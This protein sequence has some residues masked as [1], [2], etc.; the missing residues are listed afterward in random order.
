MYFASVPV[1]LEGVERSA[2]SLVAKFAMKKL[3]SFALDTLVNV[4]S[5]QE[6]SSKILEIDQSL[7]KLKVS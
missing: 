7:E 3:A 6:K 1:Q 4:G 5:E 2:L